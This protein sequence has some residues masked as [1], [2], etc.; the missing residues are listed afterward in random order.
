MM[1][2]VLTFVLTADSLE[3]LEADSETL[4][5]TARKHLCCGTGRRRRYTNRSKT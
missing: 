3:Q 2:A 1:F 5:T 4:L